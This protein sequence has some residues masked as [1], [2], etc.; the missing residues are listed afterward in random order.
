MRAESICFLIEGGEK[1]TVEF[2]KAATQVPDSFY[3]SVCAFLNHK[4]GD[5]LL[6]VDDDGQVVGIPEDRLDAFCLDITNATNNSN[7]LS[8]PYLLYPQKIRF[9]GT[10]I[11]VVQ[12]PE[13]SQVHRLRNTVYSR[14]ASGDYKVSDPEQIARMVNRKRTFFSEA[15][16]YPYLHIEDLDETTLQKTR[17]RMKNIRPNHPWLSLSTEDFLRKAGLYCR[18]PETGSEGLC[19]AAALLFGKEETIL[20]LLPFYKIDAL[21]KRSNVDRYDDRCYVQSNIIEAF[22]Q[23]MEFIERHLPDPFYLEGEVRISLRDKI[24]RELVANLL[25]H[26][27]YTKADQARILI[28]RDRV[29]FTNPCIPHWRGRIDSASIVPFQKNPLLS[30]M[31]LQ[32]GWVEEIG[33]GL[34]NVMKYLPFY[35]KGGHA[36]IQEDENFRVTVYLEAATEQATPQATPQVDSKRTSKILEFCRTPRSRE[37]IQTMLG[38][39]DREYFRKDILEPLIASGKL[40][41]TEPDKP[42]S[43]KQRYKT[44]DTAL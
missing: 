31:F 23:L 25:V 24:F 18:D 44:K 20:N 27:E 40:E 29:E 35:A 42:T 34:M 1:E 5:I 16:V 8:P 43:P 36:E 9:E 2:K 38:L 28:Y 30:K 7:L 10:W 17:E 22:I 15:K 33:S 21:L 4:G 37:E 39:K 26:R 12:V 41:L 19:L 6:G 11:I 13:S 14:G 3:E 32:L